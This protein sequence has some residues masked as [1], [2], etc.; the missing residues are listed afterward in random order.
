MKD[1]F[2]GKKELSEKELKRLCAYHDGEASKRECSSVEQSIADYRDE[3]DMYEHVGEEVR[4]WCMEQT[5]DANGQQIEIDVWR[6]VQRAIDTDAANASGFAAFIQNFSNIRLMAPVALAALLL[7][8]VFPQQLN[9]SGSDQGS[10]LPGNLDPSALVAVNNVR[11]DLSQRVRSIKPLTVPESVY[12]GYQKSLN[13][14]FASKNT[15]VSVGNMVGQDFVRGGL[16]AQGAD[17]D[18]IK[19]E[20]E[21]DIYPVQD[22]NAPPVIWVVKRGSA[23]QSYSKANA[24]RVD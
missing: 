17:I 16:R 23:V 7:L 20:R 14:R 18:W 5:C 12:V 19:S 24:T 13:D 3:L 11:N 6:G 15:R 10:T 22:R 4:A 1:K 8:V 9:F 2:F 21:F